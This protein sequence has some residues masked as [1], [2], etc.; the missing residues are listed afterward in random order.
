M[1]EPTA[2][3]LPVTEPLPVPAPAKLVDVASLSREKLA[4][5]LSEELG[6]R[7]FRA[8]QLYRWLHQRGATS[9]DEMTDL[10]KALR[11]KLKVKAEIVP[12]VKDLEQRSVDGTIKYRFKTRDGRFIESVYMP[13]E[14]RKTLCVSTQVGCAMACSFC[15]TGTLGLKRNLTPGEIVAQVHAVNREVRANEGLE[16]LRPLTNLVFMGMGEP[17]HNFE[18][19]KTA[20]SILQSEEGPNFSHRHITVSTVG[21]VPMIE[22]FGQETDV[23]LAI[24]LNASTDEQ[25]SKTM[26]VNRKWNIQALLDACRKFPLR[27]GRRI[28]FEYV[29]LK[30]FNDTDEDAHRLKE[31]LRDIPAK[32]N[33]IPYNENPGLGFQTTG[34]QRAEEFRAI[35]AEAHVAAYIRKN[36]GRDIAGACGQL[37]NRDET[38]AEAPV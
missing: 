4:L 3:A 17:L 20:L 33:L 24:S 31:L 5:F 1:S 12:L 36:R 27:Q 26:P 34:E 22:R 9:F 21:L 10:S 11:E 28:T 25:R 23:K 16:T 8:A 15:M 2:T 6:E 38:A 37:A 13:S 35:L 30:G 7:P 19:L 14:D 29:L 18:N 32:V